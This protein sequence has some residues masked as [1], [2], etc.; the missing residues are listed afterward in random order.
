MS[1]DERGLN[2]R[3]FSQKIET[4]IGILSSDEAKLIAETMGID[5]FAFTSSA[6]GWAYVVNEFSEDSCQGE[7]K[8]GA[9]QVKEW[10]LRR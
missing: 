4:K 10:V 7:E 3:V 5:S 1:D 2:K 6:G 9:N 8:R